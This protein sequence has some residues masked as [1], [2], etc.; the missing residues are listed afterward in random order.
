M[1]NILLVGGYGF[2]GLH[3]LRKLER[4][5]FN[6]IVYAPSYNDKYE[7]ARELKKV[8]FEQGS[9]TDHNRLYEVCE[10][11]N[12]SIIIHMAALTG[13]KKCQDN[14]KLA[15]DVNVNGTYGVVMAAVKSNSHLIFI[16]SR[17]VYGE[18]TR[19]TSLE[20]DEKFP[21]NVYGLT[22][23]LDENIIQWA[24]K[25]YGLKFTIVRPTNLYG[26][27]GDNYGAQ[28][29]IKKFVKNEKIQ[30]FGGKQKMNFVHVEDVTMAIEKVILEKKSLYQI[31]NVGSRY[32]LTINQFIETL[33]KVTGKKA[34]KEFLPMR[35]AETINFA[36]SIDKI[37]DI[38]NW[39]PR[40]SL[41]E[42]LR[43]T[44]DWYSK[45]LIKHAE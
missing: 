39:E 31:F 40:I 35:E 25:K 20:D 15:F 33:E 42:G 17:E 22:K 9:I 13:I 38:L 37:R 26:P 12:P 44:F 2:T 21:N 30:I 5:D 36:V 28:T 18:T 3:L 4:Y 45:R 8:I 23:L 1:K 29:L 19:D 41:E 16:S 43:Q 11:Y 10:K 34:E 7:L 32:D 27:G 14:P 6:S 24:F